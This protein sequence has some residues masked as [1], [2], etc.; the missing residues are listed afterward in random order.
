MPNFGSNMILTERNL[1]EISEDVLFAL[2]WISDNDRDVWNT[3]EWNICS[4]LREQLAHKFTNLSV[5]VELVKHDGR[6][7][8]IVIHGRGH[9]ESNLA[10]FQV[11][12]SPDRQDVVDDLNKI[13]ETFF[14]EPYNYSYGFFVSIGELPKELPEFDP[15][16][17]RLFSVYGWAQMSDEE[18][19]ERYIL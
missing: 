8:D 5:D 11:K 18:W 1:N 10:V 14:V 7:P 9:N 4:H 6:R 16:R 3:S 15:G 19:K 13:K 2:K 12:K 17:I